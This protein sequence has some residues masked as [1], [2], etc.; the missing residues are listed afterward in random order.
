[1]Q[2]SEKDRVL[3]D[4]ERL[5]VIDSLEAIL[6][7]DKFEAAPQMSAFLRYVVEQA[8]DGNQSRIKAFTV[9]VDALGKPD[10]FDPQNDPVVRVL[11]GRLRAALAAYNDDNPD[12]LVVITMTPGSYVPSFGRANKNTGQLP[13]EP[14]SNNANHQRIFA[15]TATSN[16]TQNDIRGNDQRQMPANGAI[17]TGRLDAGLTARAEIEDT[18][19]LRAHQPQATGF[20]AIRQAFQTAPR[21][22]VIATIVA[23]VFA[24]GLL[25]NGKFKGNGPVIL[26][27]TPDGTGAEIPTSRIRP[28]DPTVF[29]SAISYGDDLENNLNTLVSG[30]ISESEHVKLNRILDTQ[31][32]MRFWPEDYI[33]TVTVVDVPD[34]TQVNMLLVEART[35][36]FVHS[37]TTTLNSQA[38]S[39]LS[40]VELT[41]VIATVRTV[42]DID[43]PLLRDF[44][45]RYKD[46]KSNLHSAYH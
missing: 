26:A 9:A 16:G 27:A 38:A 15:T 30:A 41:N 21:Y 17:G 1:M 23:V 35:G 19:G 28:L 5:E 3:D 44:S 34:E 2:E 24:S 32:D 11:A 4:N 25:V 45:D 14:V 40:P 31:R 37:E 18:E 43:G 13:T 33:L 22:A 36:R 42:V 29:V 12:A 10:S 8:A 39:Q 7:T 6:A 46:R 20:A